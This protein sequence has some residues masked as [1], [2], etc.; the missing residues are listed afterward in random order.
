MAMQADQPRLMT[1]WE[2]WACALTLERQHGEDALSFIADRIS[3]LAMAGDFDGVANW[4]VI[5]T[6]FDRLQE[7]T[8]T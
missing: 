8:W 3:K 5:A 4:K 2:L 1:E 6:R 7:A